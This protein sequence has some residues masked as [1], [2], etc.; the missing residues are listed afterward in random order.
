MVM[1]MDGDH[2]MIAVRTKWQEAAR[3]KIFLIEWRGDRPGKPGLPT[4]KLLRNNAE[5][6]QSRMTRGIAG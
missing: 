3:R 5:Q 6:L 4:G 2:G 1:M